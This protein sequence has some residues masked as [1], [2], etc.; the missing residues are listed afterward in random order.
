MFRATLIRYVFLNGIIGFVV[1]GS[2]GG[3]AI[4][5]D[6][7][8]L[9]DM[10]ASTD[11]GGLAA[12]MLCFVLGTTIGMTQMGLAIA[13]LG[14]EKAGLAFMRRFAR[15]MAVARPAPDAPFDIGVDQRP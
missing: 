7:A 13:A 3:L 4:L 9:R 1:G 6:I 11:V 8:G 12:F 2:I 10:M 5:F 15:L 14:E